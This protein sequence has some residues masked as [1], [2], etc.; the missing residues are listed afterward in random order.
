[1]RAWRTGVGHF[2]HESNGFSP[3]RTEP[4][5]FDAYQDGVLTGD[6]ILQRG[7]R[8]DEVAGFVDV[9][10]RDNRVGVVPLVC[11][12][13]LPS[14]LLSD[15]AA[16]YLERSLRE[17]LQ[18]AG[19]LDGICFA[20]HGA[21]SAVS[22]PDLD[23][24]MLGILRERIGPDVPI[25]VALDCH[26]VVTQQMV[27]LADA[28][29]AYRTHP[30]TDRVATGARAAQILLDMLDGRI[31]PVMCHQK[32][33]LIFPPPDGG[34]HEGALKELFDVVKAWDG[35]EGVVA[36]S[37][38]PSF[39][40]QDMAEQGCS[41]LAVT[42]ND[43]ELGDR[44]V[45]ELATE[46]WSARTRLHPVPMVGPADALRQ[47]AAVAGGPVIIT[48]SA[49]T[50]GGGAPGDNAVILEAALKGRKAI[51]GLILVHVPDAPAAAA[52][53]G[54][55]VGETVR[56]DV[57]GKRDTR[58]C[59]P[60]PVTAQVLAVAQGPIHDDFGAGTDSLA[61]TGTIICLGID[62]V[63]LVLSERVIHGPQPSLFRKVGI[64]PFDAKVVILKTGV[65]FKP[66][67]GHV[68]RAVIRADCPG[69]ESYHLENYTFERVPRPMYPLDP[70]MEW[71]PAPGGASGR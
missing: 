31:K 66:T 63:R 17:S 61:Q 70:G 51:D 55:G 3:V 64:E 4:E 48:D 8:Q 65:G 45:Q 18:Q 15:R 36:G 71:S 1:M 5:D 22:I 7:E 43:K 13:A 37:L 50:V 27:D 28:L 46:L 54:A 26:A 23:G 67:Y 29:I 33:P 20:L 42:D 62:N 10:G 58:F 35:R 25:V 40:W 30:H 6:S 53:R 69:V 52:I 2:W 57:G 44:L 41:V 39:A 68:A 12:G 38:C 21:M 16:A 47:A 24:Y 60:H 14:G 19:D 56:V 9:L 49:D 34:T 32:V 11:A 59:R